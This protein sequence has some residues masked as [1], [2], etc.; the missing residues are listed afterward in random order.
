WWSGWAMIV[1]TIA[2][3]ASWAPLGTVASR[4]RMKCTRQTSTVN[5]VTRLGPG[6][7]PE[8]E[9][10]G[11]AGEAPAIGWDG[12]WSGR[13]LSDHRPG[14][15]RRVVAGAFLPAPP[16]HPHPAGRETSER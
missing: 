3:T 8:V 7:T 11:M 4:F 13:K 10:D 16:R 15:E 5:L 2:A 12:Q 14:V 9:H 1:R 6:T